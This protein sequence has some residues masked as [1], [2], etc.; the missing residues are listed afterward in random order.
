MH[1]QR[2][3]FAWSYLSDFHTNPMLTSSD[4]EQV[5]RF[6]SAGKGEVGLH[7]PGCWGLRSL[8]QSA[9]LYDS[10]GSLVDP[11][12]ASEV[13]MGHFQSVL[14][15][16]LRSIVQ[17]HGVVDLGGPWGLQERL[18]LRSWTYISPNDSNFTI[19]LS[20]YFACDLNYPT[21]S[22]KSSVVLSMIDYT[23]LLGFL[24]YSII[25]LY[26]TNVVE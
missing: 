2:E 15:S 23:S 1:S 18:L 21:V 8:N 5:S 9:R 7:T 17:L 12:M 25:W 22:W 20:D 14:I 13:R 6:G 10:V 24:R 11:K 16:Y 26:L 19:R 3:S 4:F